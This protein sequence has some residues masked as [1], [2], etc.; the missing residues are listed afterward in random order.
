MYGS[1]SLS[2]NKQEVVSKKMK[3]SKEDK[4]KK[5]GKTILLGI[6]IIAVALLYALIGQ[7]RVTGFDLETFVVVLAFCVYMA[8]FVRYL[9]RLFRQ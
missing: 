5:H 9:H 8:W 4:M 7:T 2:M 3:T 6:G 1:G